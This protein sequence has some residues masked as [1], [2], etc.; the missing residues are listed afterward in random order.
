VNVKARFYSIDFPRTEP[1]P[2]NVF[3]LLSPGASIAGAPEH[4]QLWAA[5]R[6]PFF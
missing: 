4:W 6:Y 1:S 3:V 2:D 5:L